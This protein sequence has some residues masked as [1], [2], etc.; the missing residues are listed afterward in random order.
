MDQFRVLQ[1]RAKALTPQ[2]IKRDVFAFI[3][4]LET[5]LADYNRRALKDDSVDVNGN[6]IGFYSRATEI[7]SQAKFNLGQG[8]VKAQGEPFDLDDTGEFLKSIFSKVRSDNVLFGSNDPKLNKILSNL[9]TTDIFGLSD[10][11]LE[12]VINERILPFL[13]KYFQNKLFK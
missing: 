11:D 13:I 6:P 2:K 4:T 9:L 7:I 3:R 5:E 8:R 12:R 10:L 1:I